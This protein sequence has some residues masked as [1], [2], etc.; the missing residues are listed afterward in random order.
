MCR[1]EYVTALQ[2]RQHPIFNT[3]HVLVNFLKIQ[4]MHTR[5]SMHKKYVS[6]SLNFAMYYCNDFIEEMHCTIVEV[7]DQ[8]KKKMIICMIWNLLSCYI[9]SSTCI[10]LWISDLDKWH[11]FH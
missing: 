5:F 7:V 10:L 8:K 9:G 11:S 4:T 2:S 1:T 6:P 3:I